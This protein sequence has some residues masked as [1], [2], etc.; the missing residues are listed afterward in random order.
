MKTSDLPHGESKKALNF[1]HFPTRCQA[2]VWRNWGLVPVERIARV[3]KT[4][5]EC[6]RTLGADMGLRYDD[7]RCLVWLERGF[8][9]IIRRNWHLLPYEQLLELLEWTPEQM[10]FVLKE[11]DFFWVKLGR[12]KP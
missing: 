9:S 8:L 3:L 2:V 6:V 10:A 7:S 11:D 5:A 1:P 4:S 12:L